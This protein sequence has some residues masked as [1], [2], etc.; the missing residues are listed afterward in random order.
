MRIFL[1]CVLMGSIVFNSCIKKDSGCNYTDVNTVAVSN[2]QAQLKT[3]LDTSG[4]TATKDWRGF[5]Y[6]VTSSGSG[7][8]AKPCSQ[9][10][11]SYKGWLT[12]GK[13]F[14]QQTNAVFTSLGSLI[15]GWREAM[16]LI[17]KGGRMLLY[18]PPSL[19]YGPKNLTDNAGNTVVPSNSIIIFDIN[20][21]NVQ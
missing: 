14:D 12:N 17:K 9:I 6:S 8:T 21:V 10:T 19:G 7:D 20:L 13:V 1:L 2:E 3:Y 15:D 4:I 5:Y 11:V 16:P 18:I